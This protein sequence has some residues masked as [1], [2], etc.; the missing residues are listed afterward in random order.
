MAQNKVSMKVQVSIDQDVLNIAYTVSNRSAG[1]I[2]LVNRVTRV[3]PKKEMHKDIAYIRLDNEGVLQVFKDIPPVPE[4]MNPYELVAPFVTPVRQGEEF[5]ET[6]TLPVPIEQYMEYVP[7]D[8]P[9]PEY[10]NTL[11]TASV[12]F[13]LGYFVGH[14][15]AEERVE[16][17]FDQPVVLFTNPPGVIAQHFR[18]QSAPV[19]IAVPVYER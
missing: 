10:T 17:Y 15:D 8:P 13:S 6:I 19:E 11:T 14:P 9:D 16:T 18:L 1:N 7:N 2:Y 3:T 4:G 5:V 12:R